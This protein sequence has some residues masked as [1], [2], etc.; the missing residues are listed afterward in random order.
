MA[1]A[2][3]IAEKGRFT[4]NPNPIV[5]CIIVSESE[6]FLAEGFHLKAGENHAEINALAAIDYQAK[7]TTVYVSL[8][9]CSHYGRTPPCCDALIKAQVKRVVIAMQDPDPKVSGRGIEKM[10]AAGIKVDVGLM[11]SE[12]RKLNAGFIQRH[13][14]GRPKVTLKLAASLDGKTALSNGKSKWITGPLA[15]KDVQAHRARS[16]AIISGSGTVL[17]DDP[18]LNVRPE[19]FSDSVKNSYPLA[20]G[21]LNNVRQPLK[22]IFDGRGQLHPDLKVFANQNNLVVNLKENELLT[23]K[24]VKQWQ[25]PVDNLQPNSAKINLTAAMRHLGQLQLNEIWLEAGSRLAG[26]FINE[27]LVD[28]FILYLAPKVMGHKASSLLELTEFSTMAEV[29]ELDILDTKMVGADIKLTTRFK[30]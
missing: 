25:A 3:K 21:N 14:T 29:P 10:R 27:Q 20:A 9:P 5:G 22:V 18:L 15:R 24:G 13:S 26:A 19:E 8:E 16:C 7:N 17:A 4:A 6:Q 1:R 11:E 28:E 2:I 30:Y 23:T 12:A